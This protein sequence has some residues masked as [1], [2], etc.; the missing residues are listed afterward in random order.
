MRTPREDAFVRLAFP[1]RVTVLV[2]ENGE[3]VERNR[4]LDGCRLLIPERCI[5]EE[6]GRGLVHVVIPLSADRGRIFGVNRPNA[7]DGP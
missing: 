2:G 1:L 7:R 5:E 4:G 6:V 3:E